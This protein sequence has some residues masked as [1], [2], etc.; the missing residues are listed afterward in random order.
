MC[1]PLGGREQRMS[2]RLF[3][4]S[5]HTFIWCGLTPYSYH[6]YQIMPRTTYTIFTYMLNIRMF[7]PT[8]S[9]HATYCNIFV[10]LISGCSSNHATHSYDVVWHIHTISTFIRSHH[11]HNTNQITHAADTLLSDHTDWMY[12]DQ[13]VAL[14]YFYWKND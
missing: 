6:L 13:H 11:I 10:C 4:K 3:I 8:L 9:N 2:I 1:F 12:L 14:L 7:I 5:R